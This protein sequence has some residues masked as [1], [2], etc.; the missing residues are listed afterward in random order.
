MST[1]KIEHPHALATDE[2]RRRLE[3]LGEYLTRRHGIGVTWPQ[4]GKATVS[5]RY[6]VVDIQGEVKI[7]PAT[8]QFE[9]KDPGFLWRKKAKEYLEKKLEQ[10][11]NP[12]TPIT[13]LPRG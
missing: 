9:G 1:M 5:G 11:L 6:L 13:S 8:V 7:D 10:Y 3:A 2:V 4:E 12:S